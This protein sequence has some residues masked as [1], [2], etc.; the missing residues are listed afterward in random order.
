MDH[1]KALNLCRRIACIVRLELSTSKY[2]RV[3][4]SIDSDGGDEIE[5]ENDGLNIQPIKHECLGHTEDSFA[6]KGIDSVDR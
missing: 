5:S 2:L 1:V 6:E 3:R 4:V